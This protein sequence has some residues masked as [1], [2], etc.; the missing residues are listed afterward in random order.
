M[1]NGK[2]AKSLY[3][4]CETLRQTYLERARDCAE[5]TIPTLVPPEGH[6]Y[7]TKYE[8]PYQGIGARGVNNLASK[9]LLTLFPPNSPF[10]RLSVDRYKLR[11]MGGDDESKTELEKALSEIERTV[12]REV[13]TSALRV[14]VFEALKHLVV[15]GNV[16]VF[17]PKEGGIRVFQLENYIVKRDPFGNVLHIATKETIS[18]TAL[19]EEVR[20][21]INVEAL[22][23]QSGY[24]EPTVELYTAVCREDDGR[25]YVWQEVEGN[26][27]PGTEGY[28]KEEDNP[29]IALR[30]S[31]V[32]GEDYGR[33][34]VEEYLGDLKSL[35]A[36]TQSI[37]KLAAASANIKI[38]VDP[39]GTTKAKALAESPSGAFVSGRSSD[40]SVMQLEKYADL[41]VA[42]EVAEAIEQRLSYAFLL[43]AAVQRNAERVTAEEIRFMA[44]EL[45]SALGGAYSILS[46]E[47]QLPLVTRIMD[48]MAKEKRLPKLPKGELVK[49]MIVTG[50]E[51]LGRGNDL[52]KLDMFVAGVGQIFGPEA[53]QQYVNVSD[54]LN[55]R[56]TSL[57]IDTE[58]LIRSQEDVQAEMQEQ[59]QQMM[60][61][62]MAEKLGPQ[63]IR[64]ATE[65]GMADQG[66]APAEPESPQA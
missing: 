2:T 33:G 57:G 37:V 64:S 17:T 28:F 20:S 1:Y 39:N 44:Q 49:P 53:I 43:N 35:E 34:L 42:K 6:S 16:L 40:V 12:M 38:L 11:E 23:R 58:G 60:M 46:Q 10:F 65:V 21:Q 4:E 56:A 25:F 54:Y 50:V 7:A 3:S 59:Q 14:P 36:L 13:E 47:F 52:N 61:A 63:A 8:T 62:Q 48:R 27:I 45:E 26:A 30:Y 51:A 19:P 5:L 41:R 24:N 29:Y 22:Q 18:P 15:S 31:R 9:L 55:R 32:D 66:E